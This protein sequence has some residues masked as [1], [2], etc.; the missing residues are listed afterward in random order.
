MLMWMSQ[1]E[2]W[3]GQIRDINKYYSLSRVNTFSLRR[4]IA[5][6]VIDAGGYS[7]A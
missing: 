7:L 5:K 3:T 6:H 2:E 4:K 1:E